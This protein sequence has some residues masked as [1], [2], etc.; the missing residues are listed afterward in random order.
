M[1]GSVQP[2]ERM[3]GSRPGADEADEYR[4]FAFGRVGIR[5]QMTLVVRR[6]TGEF[7][8]FAYAE[9]SGISGINEDNG[10]VVRF[11]PRLVA[12][13]G[14]NLKRLFGYVCNFRA[15]EILEAS[16]SAAL[17]IPEDE[18]VVWNASWTK[19]V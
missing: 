6:S 19:L 18:P 17:K 11:G 2:F 14:K 16:G 3:A 13:E 1:R 8:G 15:A 12:I 7:E 10:F 9:F 5:P 4:A